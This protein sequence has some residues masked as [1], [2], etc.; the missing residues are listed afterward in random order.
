MTGASCYPVARARRISTPPHIIADPLFHVGE[1]LNRRV[2]VSLLF[3]LQTF[4]PWP[5]TTLPL[6]S[7]HSLSFF[8]VGGHFLSTR[9]PQK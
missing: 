3:Y 5:T 9:L 4:L 7:G 8:W 2:L 1:M 6:S